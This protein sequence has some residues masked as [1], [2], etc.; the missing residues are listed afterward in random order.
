MSSII[1]AKS[2]DASEQYQ[3]QYDTNW[4]KDFQVIR[5]IPSFFPFKTAIRWVGRAI[6]MC[7]I[8][9]GVAVVDAVT[10]F[11]KVFF[12][13]V[14]AFK[15]IH[16]S[17]I[18]LCWGTEIVTHASPLI[19]I[20]WARR[21]QIPVAYGIGAGQTFL[22]IASEFEFQGCSRARGIEGVAKP[23]HTGNDAV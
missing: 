14:I 11:Q 13:F 20:V 1:F 9:A 4:Q 17:S 3:E 6:A 12:A 18:H 8:D 19:S 5:W 23:R 10:P 7:L 15:T 2:I 22:F 16:R 21:F